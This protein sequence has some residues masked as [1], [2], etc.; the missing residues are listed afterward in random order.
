MNPSLSLA[1]KTL[2]LSLSLSL[3]LPLSLIT[4]LYFTLSI[5]SFQALFHYHAQVEQIEI[6]EACDALRAEGG[7]SPLPEQQA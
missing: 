4:T 2:S 7:G 5:K 3:S 6:E 1:K